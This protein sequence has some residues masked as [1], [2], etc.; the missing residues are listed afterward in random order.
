MKNTIGLL[1]VALVGRTTNEVAQLLSVGATTV[2]MWKKAGRVS[3]E[4]AAKLAELLSEPIAEW[5]AIA[6]AE[7]LPE[8]KRGWLLRQLAAL[9]VLGVVGLVTLTTPYPAEGKRLFT[10]YKL[11]AVVMR[12]F[13]WI[14]DL[15]HTQNGIQVRVRSSAHRFAR[16]TGF[17]AWSSN[18][19]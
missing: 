12:F 14:A 19:A 10:Q 11:C 8:P 1:N 2:T 18:P 6:A 7:A 13:A 5:V 17:F 15:I 16:A 3:P 4:G 9:F